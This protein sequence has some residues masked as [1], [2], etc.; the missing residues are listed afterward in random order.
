MEE[1]QKAE[2]YS[3]RNGKPIIAEVIV[4]K[5]ERYFRY[6]NAKHGGSRLYF[7]TDSG[8]K[9]LHR[10]IWESANGPIPDGMH[11]HH[12]DFNSLNNAL[13]NMEL[14]MV[15][16][17]ERLH[18]AHDKLNRKKIVNICEHCGKEFVAIRKDKMFC[19]R[20]CGHMAEK[21]ESECVICGTKFTKSPW[22]KNACCSRSCGQKR[23]KL[24]A[25]RANE[26]AQKKQA[27]PIKEG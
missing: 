7:S 23:R 10:E 21:T 13:S 25:C 3:I 11:I 15:E 2:S 17:H 16:D 14:L 20:S 18:R 1:I 12:K 9:V 5:G 26:E 6:P 4:Y 24:M 27:A 8:R 19:S 22:K